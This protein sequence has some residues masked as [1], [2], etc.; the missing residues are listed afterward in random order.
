M[1]PESEALFVLFALERG[2]VSPRDLAD[3]ASLRASRPEQGIADILVERGLLT[4]GDRAELE[5]LVARETASGNAGESLLDLSGIEG[6]ESGSLLKLASA[7]LAPPSGSEDSPAEASQRSILLPAGPEVRYRG[8]REIGRGAL[9]RV[10]LGKDGVLG[11]DVAIKEMIRPAS[12]EK[13]LRRFLREGEIAGRLNHPNVIPV[14]DVGVR[15]EGRKRIPYFVMTRIVGRDLRNIIVAVERGSWESAGEDRDKGLHTEHVAPDTSS[16][17]RR[18]FTRPRLLGIFQDICQAMAYAHDRGVVHRDLKPANVMVGEY[19]EV[20][21]VDWG[22]AKTHIKTDQPDQREPVAARGES[23]DVPRR[24]AG[25]TS[26]DQGNQP[27]AKPH[28]DDQESADQVDQAPQVTLEG[29]LIGTPAYMSP[30]QAAGRVDDIDE[31]SDIYSLGAILYEILTLH[32]PFDGETPLSVVAKVIKGDLTPPSQKVSGIRRSV[33][34]ENAEKGSPSAILPR[35]Q[36]RASFPEPVP[37]ELDEIVLKAMARD[38]AGRYASVRELFEEIQRFLE[39]E[40]E[41]E[42]RRAEAAQRAAEGG[43]ALETYRALDRQVEK[44]RLALQ[45]ATEKT[46]SWQPVE[47]KE[48]VWTEQ[49]RIRK[50]EEE[51]MDAFGRAEVAFGQALLADPSSEAGAEGRCELY[52]ERFLKAERRRDRGEMVYY[53]NLIREYD[54]RGRWA[55]RIGRPGSLDIRTFEGPETPP[56]SDPGWAVRF[57]DETLRPWR[58]GRPVRDASPDDADR[59]VPEISHRVGGAWKPVPLDAEADRGPEVEGIRVTVHRYMERRYR[60]VLEA[61]KTPGSTP[62]A[63]VALAPGSYLCVLEAEGYARVRL[64]VVIRR[65]ET[66]RA[67]VDLYRASRIPPGFVQVTG[68]PFAAGVDERE[69]RVTESFFIAKHAVTFGDY[70]AFLDDLSAGSADG[71][72]EARRRQPRV[73]EKTLLVEE[74]GRWRLP[75]SGEREGQ[76]LT[77][78]MPVLGISWFDALAYCAWVS[79]RDGRLYTPPHEEEWE[80][81]A[82]G[83]D[84]RLFPWGDRY[85]STFSNTIGTHEQGPRIAEAG[86]F[87]VDES[88]YGVMDMAGNMPTWCLNAPERIRTDRLI[89]GGAWYFS[90][91]RATT[92]A[93]MGMR[94]EVAHVHT[95]LRLVWRPHWIGSGFPSGHSGM[96]P[97]QWEDAPT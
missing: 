17:P 40:K 3:G 9:G 56:V 44:S 73:P 14:H 37:P 29:D 75:A 41:R 80:K 90:D 15:E 7:D 49:D 12:S 57:A 23:P 74:R 70:L 78:A 48:E 92:A 18:E 20:Y 47:V 1:T 86:T 11:R 94:P 55:E 66:T 51:R 67:D 72:E 54:R 6:E 25:R 65:G 45:E 26:P 97:L 91:D 58:K 85:D 87:P 63:G 28:Q 83:T 59:P 62:L 43:E 10:I 30:E 5:T 13:M 21:V 52:F 96:N 32:P 84:G 64:P 24:K 42:R 38:K 8:R 27:A 36:R 35:S 4:P 69:P 71:L 89:R 95:G 53:E 34:T 81:A 60:L 31:R 19:G 68:G 46:K 33:D 79:S 61:G 93:R 2:F 82:R 39:G 22:L 76:V 16:D 77:E 50:L 88:P